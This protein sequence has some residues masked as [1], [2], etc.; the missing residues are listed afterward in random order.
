MAEILLLL[1][2]SLFLEWLMEVD[3]ALLAW[4][5]QFAP[6]PTAGGRRAA[7]QHRM[8]SLAVRLAKRRRN[9]HVRMPC[10]K[11][12]RTEKSLTRLTSY[13]VKERP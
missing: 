7:I 12:K 1:M 4:G 5:G 10:I 6:P 13:I 11:K 2:L 8:N 9:T 3:L